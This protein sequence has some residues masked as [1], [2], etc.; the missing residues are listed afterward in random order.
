MQASQ[1][2]NT[3]AFHVNRSALDISLLLPQACNPHLASAAEQ[4][5]LRLIRFSHKVTFLKQSSKLYTVSTLRELLPCGN[6]LH[7][8]QHGN[9]LCSTPVFLLIHLSVSSPRRPR[10]WNIWQRR[11]NTSEK[12]FRKLWR[13]TI[14]SAKWQR[15]S[16]YWKWNRSKKTVKLI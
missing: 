9:V 10:C 16:W 5:V 3:T 7:P 13:R 11:E 14:T 12:C 2:S 15:K 6:I 1:G 8:W 4:V